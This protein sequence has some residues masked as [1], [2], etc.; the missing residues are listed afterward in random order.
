M[1]LPEPKEWLL[2]E[3]NELRIEIDFDTKVKLRVREAF[4]PF[5]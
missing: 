1:T 4:L 5:F 3:E 2:D